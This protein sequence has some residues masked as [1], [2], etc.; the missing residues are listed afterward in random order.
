[1]LQSIGNSVI[2]D[3]GCLVSAVRQ[4]QGIRVAHC[5]AVSGELQHK[6][7]VRAVTECIGVFDRNPKTVCQKP[8][9]GCFAEIFLS[10][11]QA[12]SSCM[13]HRKCSSANL[14]KVSI[15]ESADGKAR[16]LSNVKWLYVSGG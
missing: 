1:M 9:S 3:I 15:S 8:D 11:F 7:I 4:D 16:N 10:Q 13:K 14:R 2:F 5:D 6:K 12:L